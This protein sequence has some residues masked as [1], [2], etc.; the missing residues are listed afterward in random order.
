MHDLNNYSEIL[1]QAV[2][3]NT[4]DIFP[5]TASFAVNFQCTSRCRYCWIWKEQMDELPLSDMISVVDQLAALGVKAVSLS[6]GEPL[7]RYDLPEIIA[8]IRSHGM[9]ANITTNGLLFRTPR[10]ERAV[11]AGLNSI[12]LSLD[13]VDPV[14]YQ[15]I[16]GV[17]LAPVLEGLHTILAMMNEQPG[18][19]VSANCVVS[20]ANIN[21]IMELVEY[22][23]T[24]RIPVGFQPLHLA[25]VWGETEREQLRFTKQDMPVL[26]SLFR[27]LIE[28]RDQGYHISNDRAY[29]CGFPDFLVYH[30]LP[31]DFKCTTGFTTIAID[32]RLNVR[33]CWSMDP[34]GNLRETSLDE[35]W[36]SEMY[37]QRRE[38]MLA[39]ACPR[40]WLRC[41]TEHCSPEW[42]REFVRWVKQ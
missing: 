39:L 26:N 28:L 33:S 16:R 14:V 9:I 41:H 21:H 23:E 18:L 2:E 15:W 32:H 42:I 8:R 7:L 5:L 30:R 12:A 25:G 27:E 36:H 4:F 1:Q 19:Q 29:L 22:C 11:R 24:W 31:N 35:L 20:R 34:I 3:H 13:T 37:R 10:L 40:C 38:D 17:P 6:G